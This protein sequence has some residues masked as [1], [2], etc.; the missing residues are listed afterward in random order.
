MARARAN[1]VS[2]ITANGRFGRTDPGCARI[3][4]ANNRSS[5]RDRKVPA[6]RY[7]SSRNG[8]AG[9]CDKLNRNIGCC[10]GRSR[11]VRQKARSGICLEPDEQREHSGRGGDEH[12]ADVTGVAGNY[13]EPRS[14][15]LRAERDRSSRRDAPVHHRRR[16]ARKASED[17]HKQAF[18]LAQVCGGGS[19]YCPRCPIS[20]CWTG[21]PKTN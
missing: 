1:V 9:R 12:Q 4:S 18:G 19:P 10:A 13:L 15:G 14:A 8:P 2:G 5:G 3:A 21:R 17:D 7:R 20:R 6:V 11:R 16:H